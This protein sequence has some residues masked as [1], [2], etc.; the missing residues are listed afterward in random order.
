LVPGLPAKMKSVGVGF[1][2][3]CALSDA[4]GVFCWGNN[5]AGTLGNGEI[6]QS[7]A[8]VRAKGLES[9]V[10]ALAVGNDHVCVVMETGGVK[11]WGSNTYGQLSIADATGSRVPVDVTNLR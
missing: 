3:S 6:V 7:R 10:A 2:Y 9:G 8:V 11:C 4:G 5:S 1:H